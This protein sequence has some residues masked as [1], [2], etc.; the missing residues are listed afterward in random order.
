MTRGGASPVARIF[1]LAAIIALGSLAIHMFVP[2]MP[3]AAAALHS[4]R[5]AVQLA[6]TFYLISVA[7][8]QLVIGPLSD[9][10]GR[11]PV[12]IGGT[13]LFVAGSVLC[14]VAG[15]IGALLVGRVIQALG[16]SS[17][18]V[19]GRAMVGDEEGGRGARDMALLTAIV[20]LAPMLA[21]VIG[22]VIAQTLGWRAIFAILAVL[23]AACGLAIWLWIAETHAVDPADGSSLLAAWGRLARDP[24]YVRNLL[25]GT[26][27]SG[28]LY[29]FLAASPF[30]LVGF[31]A[32]DPVRL[33]VYYGIVALGAGGGALTASAL[34]ARC[35]ARSIMTGGTAIAALAAVALFVAAAAEQH[36]IGCFV[37][38]MVAYA[39]GGGLVTPNAITCALSA[40][41][42]R[43][44]TAV[45]IYGALQMAGSALATLG[46]ALLPWHNPVA[47]A[48][49]IAALA[50]LGVA[51]QSGNRAA[52]P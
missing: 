51:L 43:A 21:P 30:L 6:L 22:S 11:R 50:L 44:G 10:L 49:V 7:V 41:R 48:A 2:A 23:G 36:R 31:Y 47:P 19:A 4:D 14:W 20:M 45:S 8:G 13:I 24:V 25:I 37:A 12:L 35:P 3:A 5:S 1:L 29:V 40:V 52:Q 39:F 27:L 32:A 18:L 28:G 38:P 15:S 17:G 46:V 9:R 33:G 34:A 42:G 16:A 26:A